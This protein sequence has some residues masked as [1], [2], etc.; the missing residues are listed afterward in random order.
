MQ[1]YFSQ[2]SMAL[3]KDLSYFVPIDER[4]GHIMVCPALKDNSR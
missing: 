2:I 4:K 3:L 1:V